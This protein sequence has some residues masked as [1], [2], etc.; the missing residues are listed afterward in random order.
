MKLQK[1]TNRRVGNKEYVKWY[2]NLPSELIV[3]F[4]WKEGQELQ[5]KKD[6]RKLILESKE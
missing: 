3:E 4:G 2:V 5:T 6:R 1:R